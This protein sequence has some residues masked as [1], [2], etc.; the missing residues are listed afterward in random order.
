MKS[1][2]IEELHEKTG[3]WLRRV[4]EVHELVVT[5]GGKPVARLLPPL[6]AAAG[7][8]FINRSLLP[9]VAEIINR[10]VGGP[11]SAKVVSEMRR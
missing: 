4:A 8:P 2:S 10:P 7:N 11:D 6:P 9:G 3:H 1:I 5:E